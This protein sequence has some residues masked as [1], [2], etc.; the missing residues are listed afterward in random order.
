MKKWKG[1]TLKSE[2]QELCNDA[3]TLDKL[4]LEHEDETFPK[5]EPSRLVSE[6]TPF[7]TRVVAYRNL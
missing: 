5:A 3:A 1:E 2:V 7:L 4:F 6:V